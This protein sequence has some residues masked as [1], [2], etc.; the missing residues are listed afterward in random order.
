MFQYFSLRSPSGHFDAFLS[1]CGSLKTIATVVQ[2]LQPATYKPFRA[3]C[4]LFKPIWGV[5]HTPHW[6]LLSGYFKDKKLYHHSPTMMLAAL[7]TTYRGYW[8]LLLP[9]VEGRTLTWWANGSTAERDSQTNWDPK[10]LCGPLLGCSS[11][12]EHMYLCSWFVQVRMR[13]HVLYIQQANVQYY[14]AGYQQKVGW[15]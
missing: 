8:A 12:H 2:V 5:K 7:L 14:T 11:Q 9:L 3:S 13:V 6:A 4:G 10:R 15:C 1:C